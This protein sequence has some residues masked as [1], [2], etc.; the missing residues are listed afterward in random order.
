M[1]LGATPKAQEHGIV[2]VIAR[3]ERS[4]SYISPDTRHTSRSVLRGSEV[5]LSQK[6]VVQVIDEDLLQSGL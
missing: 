2:L 1:I 6:L 5:S 3:A 4:P